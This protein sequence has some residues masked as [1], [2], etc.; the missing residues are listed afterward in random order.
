MG[1]G[2]LVRGQLLPPDP[3]GQVCTSPL[4]ACPK[5]DLGA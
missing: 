4:T 2:G 1:L 3:P 5:K